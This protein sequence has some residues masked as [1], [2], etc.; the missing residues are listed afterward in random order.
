M[1]E[2]GFVYRPLDGLTVADFAP[3][4][5]QVFRVSY[6][7]YN[8]RLVLIEAQPAKSPPPTGLR[9]GF[10][11]RFES[12]VSQYYLPQGIHPLDH[13]TLGRLQLFLVPL[14]PDPRGVFLYEAVFG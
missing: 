14:G 13:A 3:L 7:E 5:G 1:I 11:L 10:S 9:H 8:Q 12:D 2:G 6:P 4:I